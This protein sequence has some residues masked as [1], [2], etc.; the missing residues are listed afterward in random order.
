MFFFA[1]FWLKKKGDEGFFLH[2]LGSKK[3]ARMATGADREFP[4]ICND[5]FRYSRLI[6][7]F[8]ELYRHVRPHDVVDMRPDP[9]ATDMQR[10]RTTDSSKQANPPR[11]AKRD[12]GDRPVPPHPRPEDDAVVGQQDHQLRVG[13][14]E[15]VVLCG[16]SPH[17][18]DHGRH[19]APHPE[20][21]YDVYPVIVYAR[22]DFEMMLRRGAFFDL[23]WRQQ[24]EQMAAHVFWTAYD[25]CDV[26]GDPSEHLVLMYDTLCVARRELQRGRLG[27]QMRLPVR[28]I[29]VCRHLAEKY[30]RCGFPVSAV[31]QRAAATIAW[32][33]GSAQHVVQCCG[34]TQQVESDGESQ[35]ETVQYEHAPCATSAIAP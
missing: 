20:R 6:M 18:L 28:D 7:V 5:R 14:L 11:G 27:M 8:D 32:R 12:R 33:D 26:D 17:L 9:S 23:T 1:F 35:N 10:K 15:Y 13:Q 16:A 31:W 29:R 19:I 22:R 21:T 34:R 4:Q 25:S 3:K 24:K 2:S 30:V